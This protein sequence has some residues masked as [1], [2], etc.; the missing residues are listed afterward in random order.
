[1]KCLYVKLV[2]LMFQRNYCRMESGVWKQPIEFVVVESDEINEA[3][4][5]FITNENVDVL[6]MLIYK[7]VFLKDCFNLA[8]LKK[9]HPEFHIPILAIHID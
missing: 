3:V 9:S 4:L 5:D 6:T 2:I 7:E 1:V 8:I